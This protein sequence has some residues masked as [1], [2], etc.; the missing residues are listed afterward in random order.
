M[1][2][3]KSKYN[4]LLNA[5][6]NKY[7]EKNKVLL[8]T[9][10][11]TLLTQTSKSLN[12]SKR[13]LLKNKNQ[14]NHILNTIDSLIIGIIDINF[15]PY[16]NKELIKNETSKNLLKYLLHE[17]N[18]TFNLLSIKFLKSF[19]IKENI[20]L[21]KTINNEFKYIFSQIY[22]SLKKDLISNLAAE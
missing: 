14:T 19:F 8:E 20:N 16:G 9:H 17:N 7:G 21:I 10:F 15:Y 22:I 3:T 5:L 4:Y 6:I 18:F 2:K 13:K 11:N 1:L 12:I